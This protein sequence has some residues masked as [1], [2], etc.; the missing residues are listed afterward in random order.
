MEYI[1]SIKEYPRRQPQYELHALQEAIIV[2]SIGTLFLKCGTQLCD[3]L[4]IVTHCWANM[5][6]IQAK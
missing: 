1:E 3:E 4:K 6:V 5:V 2:E